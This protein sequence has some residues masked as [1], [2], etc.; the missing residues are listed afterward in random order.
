[1][2]IK[3]TKTIFPAISIPSYIKQ[4]YPEAFNINVTT[5]FVDDSPLYN[6]K[7][8]TNNL[9]NL[10]IRNIIII[11]VTKNPEHN[12]IIE[13]LYAAEYENSYTKNIIIPFNLFFSKI[14]IKEFMI[15]QDLDIRV[16]KEYSLIK[17]RTT[18]KSIKAGFV[19][20]KFE[21]TTWAE[22]V[23]SFR[24]LNIIV[25][26]GND[27]K[28]RFFSP[29]HLKLAYFI[30]FLEKENSFNKVWHSFNDIDPVKDKPILNYTKP[31]K[32]IQEDLERIRENIKNENNLSNKKNNPF[33]SQMQKREYHVFASTIV[34]RFS[35][36]KH[37]SINNKQEVEINESETFN[38]LNTIKLIINS[39]DK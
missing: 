28:K 27:S 2:S 6:Y 26:G 10:G 19:I 4:S 1:M 11:T 5:Y 3:Y 35:I 20:F 25:S 30:I 33:N 31:I 15:E 17:D 9:S 32:Q 14:G 29:L 24:K 39:K 16:E 12:Q 13:K 18:W 23:I 37:S 36:Q 38:F 7:E 34:K 8:L 22:I 21:E